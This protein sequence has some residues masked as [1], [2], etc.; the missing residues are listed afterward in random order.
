MKQI[1]LI[2]I[3]MFSF[4]SNISAQSLG[5]MSSTQR[6]K[7][8]IELSSEVIKTIGPGY[9]RKMVPTIHEGVFKSTDNRL[10]VKKNV[11][12]E[13]Y[14][15]VYPYDKTKETL[16]FNFSAK[17]RIWKDTGEPCDVMFGNG[18]GRNF[19][20]LSYKEQTESRAIIEQV[21]YEQAKTSNEDIWAK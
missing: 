5:E 19:F 8:L 16:E 7:Y 21:P 13:Y 17:V 20:F 3:S 15:V 4:L 14:E 11:G 18:H 1:F 12:R 9:Y 6:N 10:E 2:L